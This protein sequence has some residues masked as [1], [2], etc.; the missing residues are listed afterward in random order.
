MTGQEKREPN[1]ASLP[2]GETIEAR[3]AAI[4]GAIGNMKPPPPPTALRLAELPKDEIAR[5]VAA[6]KDDD[7]RSTVIFRGDAMFGAGKAEVSATL[8]PTLDKVAPE[9]NRVQG[10][11]Q[12]TGHSGN[13]PIK[14]ARHASNQ[15]LSK[16]R[17]AVVSEYLA[18]KGVDKGRLEAIG[19]GDTEPLTDNKTPGARVANRRARRTEPGNLC[20][21][22]DSRTVGIPRARANQHR[23]H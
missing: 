19:K 5:S 1:P 6:V 16:E 23:G 8:L 14:S 21:D 15:A 22:R 9:I 4:N 3:V 10:K 18:R 2:A 13:Q 7:R 12:V 20:R 11:V 17:A